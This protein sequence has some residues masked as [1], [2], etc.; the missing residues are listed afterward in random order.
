MSERLILCNAAQA[1][2]SL[3]SGQLEWGGGDT[4]FDVQ[5]LSWGGN[6]VSVDVDTG[7]GFS[8][9]GA[10]STDTIQT[11]SALPAGRYRVS[12]VVGFASGV[13]VA[14]KRVL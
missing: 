14:I 5:A 4:I 12:A 7:S 13:T 8:S 3:F 11:L 2:A 6:S 10:W 1:S 9:V